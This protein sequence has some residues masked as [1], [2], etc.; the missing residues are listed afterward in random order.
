[1]GGPIPSAVQTTDGNVKS[2]L[3]QSPQPSEPISYS[4]FLHMHTFMSHTHTHTHTLL[5]LFF[6]GT[7][8]K[9]G[10]KPC[11]STVNEH[12]MRDE[13]RVQFSHHPLSLPEHGRM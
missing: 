4:R 11:A 1:M 5:V 12:F 2:W 6:W 3:S 13:I 9:T 10:K 7:L 8:T